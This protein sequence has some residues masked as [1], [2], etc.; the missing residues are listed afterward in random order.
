[1]AALC[2]VA[3]YSVGVIDLFVHIME[4]SGNEVFITTIIQ[5]EENLYISRYKFL[6]GNHVVK[7]PSV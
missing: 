6:S 4:L 7:P 2:G 1:M 3:F 5:Q